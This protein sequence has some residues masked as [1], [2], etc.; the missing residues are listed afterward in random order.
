MIRGWTKT[1]RRFRHHIIDAP[2]RLCLI[3]FVS[4][5]SPSLV[6]AAPP[7]RIATWDVSR[8]E[9]GIF[10]RPKREK[11]SSWRH[12]FGSERF[13]AKKT[14]LGIFNLDVDIVLLQG[15]RNVRALK[16]VFPTRTWKLILS[17]DYMRSITPL[18]R[19]PSDL[20]LYD[21]AAT[22]LNARTPVTAVAVR[23]QQRLRVRA[24]KHIEVDHRLGK[25]ETTTSEI[26][27][28]TAVRINHFG[29]RLWLVSLALT[30]N[31]K[32]DHAQCLPWVT[33][34]KWFKDLND[35]DRV[36]A[37]AGWSSPKPTDNNSQKKEIQPC[38]KLV[39]MSQ[40]CLDQGCIGK[41]KRLTRKKL[42]CIVLTT[43]HV[44]RQLP[45]QRA[46]SPPNF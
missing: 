10:A 30:E 13:D 1:P 27:A 37:V 4:I 35:F 19:L 45:P 33:T 26:P 17:R 25:S 23:Y 42:G 46:L 28:A 31:C 44:P 36:P 9:K 8:A 2:L 7:L 40:S 20:Q 39:A 5:A 21:I 11:K 18:S 34:N 29:S 16:R 38:G 43:V 3:L 15:I 14:R 22:E 6:T 41:M 24:I 32:G 12:T